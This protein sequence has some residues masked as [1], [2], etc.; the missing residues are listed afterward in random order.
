MQRGQCNILKVT[1]K[2]LCVC[3]VQR[4][5][6]ENLSKP[7]FIQLQTP[8]YSLNSI[9]RTPEFAAEYNGFTHTY[10]CARRTHKG[11]KGI[12]VNRA[13]HSL[14]LRLQSL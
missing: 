3:R 2:S 11:L 6:C 7:A 8:V 13:L 5:V 12:I 10:L 9:Q 14:Q 1:L 4:Y